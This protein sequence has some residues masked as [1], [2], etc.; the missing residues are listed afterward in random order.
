MF[1]NK[2][3]HG[4]ETKGCSIIFE[5]F[6]PLFGLFLVMVNYGDGRPL[7]AKQ[8]AVWTISELL[9]IGLIVVGKYIIFVVVKHGNNVKRL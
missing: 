5:L 4:I 7:D 1:F 6:F 9:H 3:K 8:A 2:I